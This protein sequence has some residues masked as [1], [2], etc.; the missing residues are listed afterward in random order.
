MTQS[1][2]PSRSEIPVEFRWDT[3]SIYATPADWDAAL[4]QLLAE[5]PAVQT[6]HGRLA[7][8]SIVLADCL[9]ASE[10][11]INRAQRAGMYAYLDYSVDTAN[12]DALGSF[13]ARPQPRRTGSDCALI[14]RTRDHGDRL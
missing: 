2:I 8:S 9:I 10:E 6:F 11:L 13:G 12:Q 1:T 7:E 14:H 3:A 5:L 4:E